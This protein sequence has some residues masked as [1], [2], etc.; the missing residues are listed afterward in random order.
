MGELRHKWTMIR[1]SRSIDCGFPVK[2]AR[3]RCSSS[4]NIRRL[5]PSEARAG[6]FPSCKAARLFCRLFGRLD[7]RGVW[8]RWGLREAGRTRIG[9]CGADYPGSGVRERMR[10]DSTS[11]WWGA[12]ASASTI[13]D[14][15][16]PGAEVEDRYLF[17]RRGEPV[18]FSPWLV[19]GTWLVG[20]C[21]GLTLVI[22]FLAISRKLRFRTIWLGIAGVLILSATLVEPAVTF[23][24]LQAAALGAFLSLLGFVIERSIERASVRLTRTGRGG[25]PAGRSSTDSPLK[26]TAAVGS[27]DPTAI[28]VRVPS[29]VDHAP[30]GT[31]AGQE[32]VPELRSSTVQR[33]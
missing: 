14:F 21:S 23:L 1:Q 30:V 7:C 5:R 10:P 26:G 9:G 13:D 11:G 20:I 12:G 31:P 32:A 22:G 19:P 2:K 8:P 27:D 17:S 15:S 4:W 3:G 6:D 16:G 33:A 29:T 18:A 25:L 24:L 28:R